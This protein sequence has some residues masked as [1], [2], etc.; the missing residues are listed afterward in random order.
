MK[1][2]GHPA[3]R[4]GAAGAIAHQPAIFAFLPLSFRPPAAQSGFNTPY[5]PTLTAAQ[6]RFSPVTHLHHCI[7][8]IN[9]QSPDGRLHLRIIAQLAGIVHGDLTASACGTDDL[10]SSLTLQDLVDRHNRQPFAI[11]TEYLRTAGTSGQDSFD[12]SSGESVQQSTKNRLKVFHASKIMGRFCATCQDNPKRRDKPAEQLI[13]L[14]GDLRPCT[15]EAAPRK[16]NR[17]TGIREP[18]PGK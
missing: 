18:I 8:Q 17:V 12:P 15:R 14:P 4:T 13:E 6:R 2:W 7:S 9:Q 3:E 16:K 1:G 11:I 5:G 10:H